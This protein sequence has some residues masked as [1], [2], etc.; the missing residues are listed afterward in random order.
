MFVG[1]Y[2]YRVDQKGR[3]AIPAKYR[4]YFSEG[5][6]LAK[7]FEKC[8]E[9]YTLAEW[10]KVSRVFTQQP[11]TRSKA[12]RVNRF[13]FA[14]AFVFETLDNLGRI[15]VPSPLRRYA[16][17]GEEAVIAGVGNCLEI[18]SKAL[19]EEEKVKGEAEAWNIVEGIEKRE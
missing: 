1:E 2:E 18:W 3:L 11:L 14:S 12:R 6:V 13:L 10:E 8:L 7:G 5:L 19:W 16:E 17:I 4:K 15:V 9:A